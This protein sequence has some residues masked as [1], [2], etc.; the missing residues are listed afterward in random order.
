[1]EIVN[2]TSRQRE[3][4]A[5]LQN[6][7][8]NLSF[9]WH[10]VR[11]ALSFARSDDLL[12]AQPAVGLESEN[13]QGDRL[14]FYLESQGELFGL[15]G[16]P[17]SLHP[18]RNSKDTLG[19]LHHEYQQ[20]FDTTS[21]DGRQLS[22]EVYQSRLSAHFAPDGR[23]IEVVSSLYADVHPTN[24]L[25]IEMA[26]VRASVLQSIIHLDGFGDL[27][28]RIGQAEKF[29]PLAD[30]PRL[31]IYPWQEKPIYAWAA[32]G[33]A[34]LQTETPEPGNPVL[35]IAFSRMFFNAESGELFLLSPMRSHAETPGVGTGKS[36]I[37]L[38]GPFADRTLQIVNVDNSGLYR[39]KDTTRG[40]PIVTY[41][42]K[43]AP[44]SAYTTLAIDNGWISTSESSGPNWDDIAADSSD[45]ARTASQQPEVDVH[46]TCREVYDWYAAIGDRKGWDNDRYTA[47]TVPSPAI[48]LIAHAFDGDLK[49]SRSVNLFFDPTPTF[50]RWNGC[51]VCFDGD[52]TA[53]TQPGIAYNYPAGSKALIAHEYQHGVTTFSVDAGID[54]PG[55]LL[56]HSEMAL[57]GTPLAGWGGAVHEGLSDVFAGLFSGDWWMG[58]EISPTGQIWR[59]LAFPP[60]PT[61]LSASKADHWDDRNL[62]GSGLDKGYHRGCILAHAAYLMAEGGV[63][64]RKTRMP[65][66]IPVRGLGRTLVRGQDVYKAACFWYRV[67][68]K[69]LNNIGPFVGNSADE[70]KFR[71]IRDYCVNSAIDLYGT[72]SAEHRTAL[73]AWYAV[74]LHPTGTS[75][76]PDLTF[77]T[78]GADWRWSRPYTELARPP[79]SDWSAPDLFINNGGPSSWRALINIVDGGVP[80]QFENNVFVRVRNIGDQE[81]TDIVVELEYAKIA[82]DGG[83]SAWSQ[84][85]DKNGQ[86]QTVNITT[87]GA[88]ESTFPD[89]AQDTPPAAAGVKWCIPPLA[90]GEQI[91]QLCIRA[92]VSSG[93]DVNEFNN[94]VQSNI[95]YGYYAP[96]GVA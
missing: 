64:Q 1:M 55:G 54:I 78:W 20:F 74:G 19:F 81:A 59:N 53:S 76:G 4:L 93:V 46:A 24:S 28:A 79:W 51:I 22:I 83:I 44:L 48:N 49:T 52:P 38:G 40:R 70:E 87:L 35:R 72:G 11:G 31:V 96:A 88:G 65:A 18:L 61:A 77:L 68:G 15:T 14:F 82:L 50:Q 63:H 94:E 85:L 89:S 29:F 57:N 37:P 84:V 43:A 73:L 33:Y 95:T 67:V 6:E 91:Y 2:I 69:Y 34:A 25:R 30:A 3:L 90:P 62:P 42:A 17:E 12:S 8:R 75:Y 32:L 5:K 80:T 13:R 41:N 92:R 36:T 56:P 39:L 71:T 9:A 86:A 21:A 58:R 45:A 66:L 60:D 10:E 47:T 16:K 23:L 26:D 7:N 27:A